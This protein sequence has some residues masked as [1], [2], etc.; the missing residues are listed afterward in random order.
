MLR[1]K[2]SLMRQRF[3]AA[4]GKFM[5]SLSHEYPPGWRVPE[6][7]HAS[8]QLIYGISGVMEVTVENTMWLL[9]PQF[10]LWIPGETRHSIRMPA[11][12]SMRTLYMRRGLVQ[13]KGCRVM[14]VA[15]LLR[16]LIL[17]A[18]RIADLSMRSNHHRAFV[19]VLVGEIKRASP[20]PTALTMPSDARAR[21]LAEWTIESP[22]GRDKLAAQCRRAGV[23]TRTL[24]RVFRREVGADF[25]SWRRQAR[26]M[27]AI[28]LLAA[29]RSIKEV[30]FAVGYRHPTTFVTLFRRSLGVTPKAWANRLARPVREGRRAASAR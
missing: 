30:A 18:V 29:G 7:A 22:G 20:V 23:S 19:S 17:E 11:A 12:V 28:E 10:A 3:E 2:M 21:K 15:P 8:D 25:E 14:E 16:E 24:Q 6:H 1:H 26:I 4:P 5:S 9:P 13:G 27:K